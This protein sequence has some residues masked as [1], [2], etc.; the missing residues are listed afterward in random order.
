MNFFP[1][2]SKVV[3]EFLF[4]ASGLQCLIFWSGVWM[5]LGLHINDLMEG[6]AMLIWHLQFV[7]FWLHCLAYCLS[8]FNKSY[9][10][11]I[12]FLYD[13]FVSD[14][15]CFIKGDDCHYQFFA[16]NYGLPMVFLFY[17]VRAHSNSP[18][19]CKIF[20]DVLYQLCILFFN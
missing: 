10:A 16:L 20:I 13:G 6:I 5:W 15:S 12:A 18:V 1:H 4:L 14:A 11:W 3:I 7:L 9:N 8:T 19:T 17:M 2:W